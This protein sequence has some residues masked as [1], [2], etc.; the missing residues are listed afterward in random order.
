MTIDKLPKKL[1]V[2]I[3]VVKMNYD[4]LLSINTIPKEIEKSIYEQSERGLIHTSYRDEIRLFSCIKEGDPDK[5]LEQVQPFLSSGIFVGEMSGND[6]MQFKYIAVSTIALATRYA[7]QGGLNE[8]TAYSFSDLFIR[9]VDEKETISDIIFL[10]AGKIMELTKMVKE[11]RDKNIHSPHIRK[12]ISYIDKNISKKITVKE[13]ADY[14]SVSADYLSHLF[15]KE[16]GDSLSNY[17]L[18]QKLELAKTLLWEGCDSKKVCSSLG[19]CSQS[20][21]ISSFKKEYDITPNEYISQIK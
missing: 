1:Y 5:L 2:I 7:I 13:I 4:E 19:F 11:S 12:S 14:C 20:H 18:R 3:E 9:T 17:I 8:M 21:F 15:K 6:L 10:L 16:M